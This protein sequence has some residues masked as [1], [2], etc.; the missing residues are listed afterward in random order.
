MGNS[1][2]L[3]TMRLKKQNEEIEQKKQHE[4]THTHTH[5]ERI[6]KRQ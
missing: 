4:P 2:F 5:N 3:E 6:F 1:R